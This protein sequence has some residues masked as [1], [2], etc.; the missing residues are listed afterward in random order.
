MLDIKLNAIAPNGKTYN[1]VLTWKNPTT[2]TNGIA[3]SDVD[4][5]KIKTY[6]YWR[7][8]EGMNARTPWKNFSG[9]ALGAE[10]WGGKDL[11]SAVGQQGY[12][13]VRTYLNGK[14]SNFSNYKIIVKGG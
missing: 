3:I 2:Y 7:T 14:Y 6:L 5:A 12:Y 13:C 11:P 8:K 4:R 9:S 10:F 1:Y